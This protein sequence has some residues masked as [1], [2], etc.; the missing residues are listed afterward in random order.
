MAL[1]LLRRTLSTVS[2][3][4][5]AV[6]EF[7]SY[8]F[9]RKPGAKT[10]YGM[11]K[12]RSN[13][14]KNGL[15]HGKDIRFGNNVSFSVKKTRRRWYPNVINKRVFSFALG[16][17][18]PFKMTTTALS[19]IDRAGG[20]D[21][22]LMGLDEASVQDSNYVRKQRDLIAAIMY[23]DGTLEAKIQRRLGFHKNPPAKPDLFTNGGN[24][25]E[26][27]EDDIHLTD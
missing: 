19:E 22:Y 14:A 16:E 10:G 11:N 27:E 15:Y 9:T 3:E 12:H 26:Q 5:P 18:V 17:M 25:Q 2:K 24:R 1:S 21:N 4:A 23:H 8:R 20:I 7:T 13:R 6:N